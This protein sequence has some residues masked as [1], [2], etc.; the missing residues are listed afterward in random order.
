[1][2]RKTTVYLVQ[3]GRDEL[4][5]RYCG[6]PGVDPVTALTITASIEVQGASILSDC[7]T[8]RDWQLKNNVSSRGEP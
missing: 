4:C 3:I 1:V 8:P 6:I 5:R 2:G 7:P